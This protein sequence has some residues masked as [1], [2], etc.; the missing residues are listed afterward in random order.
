[1]KTANVR[2][3]LIIATKHY[4]KTTVLLEVFLD[5]LVVTTDLHMEM[6]ELLAAFQK[7]D[8]RSASNRK[9]KKVAYL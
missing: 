9:E 2:I 6:S 5:R 3:A 4:V 8:K 7:L 1:M